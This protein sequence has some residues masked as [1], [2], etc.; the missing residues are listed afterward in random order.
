[1]GHHVMTLRCAWTCAISL[2]AASVLLL[3]LLRRASATPVKD[4]LGPTRPA[5]QHPMRHSFATPPTSLPAHC[6][7]AT[8]PS[9]QFA[10]SAARSPTPRT[11]TRTRTQAHHGDFNTAS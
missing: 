7:A 11:R 4:P 9:T 3:L 1:M 5:H 8:T 2:L 6:P 10:W